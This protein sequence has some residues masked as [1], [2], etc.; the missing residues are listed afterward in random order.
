ME[1][2]HA[3]SLVL[4]TMNK[5]WENDSWCG[6]THIQK[7][8]Y[9]LQ[10]LM[11]ISFQWNFVLYKYGPFSFDLSYLIAEVHSCALVEL[12]PEW[13]FRPRIRVTK[14]GEDFFGEDDELHCRLDGQIEF[15]VRELASKN[16]DELE[17]LTTGLYILRSKR[18]T[19][20]AVHVR[21]ARLSQLKP[22]I[23][24]VAA[25]AAIKSVDE[26]VARAQTV[27]VE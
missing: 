16:V 9:L 3:V 6:E 17:G 14:L 27:I 15:V 18:Y 12:V 23:K 4:R 20:P 22:H 8:V 1:Y 2:R 25:N 7:N 26:L 19:D 24:P 13:G 21:G 5:M 10:E 11:E